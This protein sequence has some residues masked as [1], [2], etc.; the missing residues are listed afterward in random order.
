MSDPKDAVMDAI[1]RWEGSGLVDP[2][3]AGRL[4]DEVAGHGTESTRRLSQ[5]LLAVTGASVL[6]IAGGVFLDWAWPLLGV[7]GRASVLTLSGLGVL[8]AGVVFEGRFRW[9]PAAY[10]MQTAGLAL[11]LVA[12]IYSERIWP[13][14]T[15]VSSI[16]GFL[17]LATPIVL[18]P[19]AMRRNVVMPA[20]HLTVGLAFLGVFLDRATTLSYASRV[21]LI[22]AAL[23][24]AIVLLLVGL[25]RDPAGDEHPWV[26]P[27]FVT[28]MGVGFPLV[29]ITAFDVLTM[30]ESGMLAVDAWLVLSVFLTLL[31]LRHAEPGVQR[32]WLG[33]LLALECLAWIPLGLFTAFET[34]DGPPES[35][36]LLVGGVGVVAFQYADRHEL[37]TLMGVAAMAFVV[38]VW[39]W[40]VERGG[41]LGGVLAL[42]GTAG[43][44]F[45]ASGRR[46]RDEAVDA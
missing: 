45:W 27:A 17:G 19:L 41:A 32:G 6:V 9:R 28:A 13:E 14:P 40:A 5:Y 36:L 20:V 1:A 43:L 31:G 37:R 46:G 21:Y 42:V 25:R 16:L 30:S 15:L 10:L 38:P 12:Y 29:S 23:L 24:G 44:L 34:F 33:R 22:D 18:A 8:A 11:I 35:G 39:W 7:G 4:R 3:T 26:L 2:G